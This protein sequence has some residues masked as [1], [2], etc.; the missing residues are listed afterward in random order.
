MDREEYFRDYLMESLQG[1][2]M[3]EKRKGGRYAELVEAQKEASEEVRRLFARQPG[4][5][6]EA[7]DRYVSTILATA[8]EDWMLVYQK[9]V[10]DAAGWL[11]YLG[12]L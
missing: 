9:G 4:E 1:Y 7:V 5:A 2:L 10:R 11:K 8:S 3:E 6:A 12:L